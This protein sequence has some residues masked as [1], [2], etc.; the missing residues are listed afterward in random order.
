MPGDSN[1]VPIDMVRVIDAWFGWIQHGA[2]GRSWA[3]GVIDDW[4]FELAT[5]QRWSLILEMIRRAPDDDCL[6]FVA[7]GPLEDLL[8][9]HG[10][11]LIDRV[12]QLAGQD[13]PFARTL[14]NVW[15]C[16][17]SDALYARVKALQARVTRPLE[18]RPGPPVDQEKWIQANREALRILDEL[19]GLMAEV[20]RDVENAQGLPSRPGDDTSRGKP[21][22]S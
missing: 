11:Q 12:E 3:W 17:M 8:S 16:G 21:P 2:N 7:A 4:M 18:M 10:E 6:G 22:R 15:Q 13:E 20:E 14:T 1:D 19:R 5:E 9:E